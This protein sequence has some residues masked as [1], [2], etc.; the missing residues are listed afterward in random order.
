MVA[1]AVLVYFS[2]DGTKILDLR[3]GLIFV[4]TKYGITFCMYVCVCVFVCMCVYVCV[5][6]CV[7]VMCNSVCVS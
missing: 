1:T 3:N 6:V 4:S 2:G 7:C 5:C